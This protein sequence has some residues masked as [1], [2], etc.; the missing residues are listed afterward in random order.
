MHKDPLFLR[1]K[2][3]VWILFWPILVLSVIAHNRWAAEQFARGSTGIFLYVSPWGTFH[4]VRAHFPDADAGWKD[5]L[6]AATGACGADERRPAHVLDMGAYA[7]IDCAMLGGY[8]SSDTCDDA[9][10]PA[11]TRSASS[12]LGAPAPK[13][14]SRQ[15]QTLLPLPHT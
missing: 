4:N 1:Y 13:P 2:D 14:I 11:P 15:R 6:Y 12:G 5:K 7:L 3:H 10:H 9:A 8:A